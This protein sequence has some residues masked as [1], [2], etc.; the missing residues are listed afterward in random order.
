MYKW[1]RLPSSRS[2]LSGNRRKNIDNIREI[3]WMLLGGAGV[4]ITVVVALLAYGLWR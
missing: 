2:H 3:L 1:N 4:F